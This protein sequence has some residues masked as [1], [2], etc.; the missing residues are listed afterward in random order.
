[1][2]GDIVVDLMPTFTNNV[3]VGTVTSQDEQ[4]LANIVANPSNFYVNV[5]NAD[6]PGGA[7]RG[8]LQENASGSTQFTFPVVARVPGAAG[9]AYRT[10]VRLVNTSG[11]ATDV[12]IQFY[13]G[14]GTAN[15]GPTKTV[16]ITL[17][18]GEQ[19][20][21]DDLLDSQFDIDNGIGAMQIFSARPIVAI[22]RIYNDQ[23]ANGAGTFG[24]FAAG[25]G[26]T[27]A[28]RQSGVLAGLSDSPIA[29][30]P[31]RTNVG[32][33]NAGS[34][35]ATLTL[36]AHAND[37]TVIATQTVTVPAFSQRQQHI[38][39]IFATL[40]TRENFYITYTT[41]SPN[42]FLYASVVDNENGD[43]IYVPAL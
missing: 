8:Q 36:R 25:A 27:V 34:T 17:A 14:G 38:S 18:P 2:A 20:V 22:A 15:A 37:G 23:R 12:L 42:L 29:T 41:N 26:N 16:T 35:D 32:W 9:T 21:I 24:Q 3:A 4:I 5:H 28:S 6:F 33:F 31:F 19:E 43:A 39:G 11:A 10:D 7:V 40:G 1:V 30:G 13:P